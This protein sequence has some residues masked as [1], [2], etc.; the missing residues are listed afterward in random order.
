MVAAIF[1]FAAARDAPDDYREKHVFVVREKRRFSRDVLARAVTRW[2]KPETGRGWS[3]GRGR[4]AHGNPRKN[5]TTTVAMAT[6]VKSCGEKKGRPWLANAVRATDLRRARTRDDGMIF[7]F[8]FRRD[9]T[10]LFRL[11]LLGIN[12]RGRDRHGILEGDSTRR[13]RCAASACI[14]E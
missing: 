8:A 6:C 12:F 11:R 7:C 5:A 14:D 1:A 3:R 10:H 9:E 4:D 2:K 13:Y